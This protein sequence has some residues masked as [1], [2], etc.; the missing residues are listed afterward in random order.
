M[1]TLLQQAGAECEAWSDTD[2]LAGRLPT[3]TP[4]ATPTANIKHRLLRL[5]S[6]WQPQDPSTPVSRAGESARVPP[7]LR[8]RD[9][10]SFDWNRQQSAVSTQLT[11]ENQAAEP[12]SFVAPKLLPLRPGNPRHIREIRVG[13]WG[14]LVHTITGFDHVGNSLINSL[15]KVETSFLRSYHFGFK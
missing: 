3:A 7:P 6:G 8:M 5:R 4:T 11:A 15:L 13:F 2:R 9:T 12:R 14:V 1:T 10:I